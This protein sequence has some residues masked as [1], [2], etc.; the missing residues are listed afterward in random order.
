RECFLVHGDLREEL[1]RIEIVFGNSRQPDSRRKFVAFLPEVA[2]FINLAEKNSK[3]DVVRHIPF[4]ARHL[5][6]SIVEPNEAFHFGK[7]AG[8]AARRPVTRIWFHAE[9][10]KRAV[11]A[12]FLPEKSKNKCRTRLIDQIGP[13]FLLL[14]NFFIRF[15]LGFTA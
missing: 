3:R 9:F 6:C 2:A 7:D 5:A 11:S 10:G 4:D 14:R 12:L 13:L 15:A 8:T 1:S